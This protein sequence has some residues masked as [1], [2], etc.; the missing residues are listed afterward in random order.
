MKHRIMEVALEEMHE[1]G[2]KFTMSDL[3]HRLG[4]SK[5]TLYENFDSK[6]ALIAAIFDTGLQDL[7]R[8]RIAIM[9]DNRLNITEKLQ[10]MLTVKP[11]LF[12]ETADRVKLDYSNQWA[13]Y[14]GKANL[15]TDLHLKSIMEVT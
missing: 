13:D 5:R 4:M 3:A 9:N 14:T 2:S 15:K 6:E 7:K 1:Q 8:Q 11:E 10:R 12:G